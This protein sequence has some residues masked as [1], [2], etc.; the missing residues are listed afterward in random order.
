MERNE[1]LMTRIV[2]GIIQIRLG[3][4][5]G[6]YRIVSR[7]QLVDDQKP[8]LRTVKLRGNLPIAVY[9]EDVWHDAHPI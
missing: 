7:H 6:Q 3:Y 9:V 4:N 1:M 5:W 8:W 2:D